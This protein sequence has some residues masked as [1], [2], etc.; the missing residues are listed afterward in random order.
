MTGLAL[1]P[2]SA[3]DVAQLE[4]RAKT[5]DASLSPGAVCA[6]SDLSASSSADAGCVGDGGAGWCY[7]PGSCPTD[8]GKKCKQ[9][10][11]ETEEFRN[12]AYVYAY[13][14]CP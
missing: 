7:V 10:I 6:L 5:F 2:A 11:C 13:L 14:A 8:A 1:S 9:D 4:A 3:T 12:V